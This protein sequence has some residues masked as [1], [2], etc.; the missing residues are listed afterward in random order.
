MR[1]RNTK[2]LILVNLATTQPREPMRVYSHGPEQ[3][4]RFRLITTLIS[5]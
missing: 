4:N 2:N 5:Q 3:I 1:N